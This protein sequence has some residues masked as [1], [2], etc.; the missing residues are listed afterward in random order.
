MNVRRGMRR[1]F[2]FGTYRINFDDF[3]VSRFAV[4]DSI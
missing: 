2:N 4:T 1:E 3:A